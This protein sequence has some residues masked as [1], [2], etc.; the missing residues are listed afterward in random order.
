VGLELN[1]RWYPK[2]SPLLRVEVAENSMLPA[3]RPG[4]WLLARRT[5]RVRPGQLVLAWYPS[6]P[7]FLLVKRAS[8]RV[9]GGWWLE[10]DNPAAGAVDSNRFGPVPADQVVGTV[11]FRY[12]PL[13]RSLSR[14]S[15]ADSPPPP[16]ADQWAEGRRPLPFGGKG[17]LVRG[18]SS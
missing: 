6:Q 1:V 5:R 16:L 11:L 14:T 7:G 2:H 13:R 17:L 10:S 8:R 18:V 4:D 12:R 9:A 15:H 3:L